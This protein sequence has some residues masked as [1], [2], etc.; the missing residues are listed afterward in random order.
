[1]HDRHRDIREE[2][3]AGFLAD[4]EVVHRAI[5]E[6]HDDRLRLLVNVVVLLP[7]DVEKPRLVVERHYR[8]DESPCLD[9]AKIT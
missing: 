8:V 2:I 5:A 9:S 6:D 3:P 7:I 1:M 4:L